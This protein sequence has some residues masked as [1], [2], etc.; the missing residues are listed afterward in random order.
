[1]P[2]TPTSRNILIALLLSLTLTFVLAAAYVFYPIIAAAL[3]SLSSHGGGTGGIGVVAGGLSE[4]FLWAA[5]LLEPVLFLIVFVF[6][7]RSR[8]RS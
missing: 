1:M 5:L 2:S 4:S 6:L 3:V 8:L 7:E